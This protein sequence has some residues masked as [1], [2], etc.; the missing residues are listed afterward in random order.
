[1]TLTRN[2]SRAAYDH[3]VSTGKLKGKQRLVLDALIVLG[4]ATSGEVLLEM[5]GAENGPNT[6]NVNAW[7]ARFTELAARGLI[8]ETGTRR[9]RVTG[10]TGVVWAP[11]GRTKPLDVTKGAR[12]PSAKVWRSVA[13]ALV[14]QIEAG[15]NVSHPHMAKALEGYRKLANG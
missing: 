14:M 2:T 9:C 15:I 1:M 8:R 3:L 7:R 10:R 6:S 11:T 12:E 4:P 5:R 13:A